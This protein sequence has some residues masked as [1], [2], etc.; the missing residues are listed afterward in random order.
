MRTIL[1]FALAAGVAGT[2]VAQTSISIGIN[3]PGVYGRVTIGDLPPPALVVPQPV[4]I[5]RAPVVVQRAPIYLYVPP[6]HQHDWRRYCGRYNACNQPVYFVREEYVRERYEREHPG[7]N[8]GK[9]KGWD[10][11]DDHG[12]GPGNSGK[13]H[14]NP[15]KGH[16][17]QK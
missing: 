9:H 6:E 15:G 7:W 14:G 10:K 3:Q 12:K 17:N 5:E 4:I 2:A 1:A 13:G 11:H 16:G 8:N